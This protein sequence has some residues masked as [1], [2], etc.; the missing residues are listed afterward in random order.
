MQRVVITIDTADDVW[1][2][3]AMADLRNVAEN[4]Y[5][6]LREVGF[7]DV[8]A[9]DA[10]VC[11]FL[12]LGKTC[13]H[14]LDESDPDWISYPQTVEQEMRGTLEVYFPH[15]NVYVYLGLNDRLWGG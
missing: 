5:H 3:E 9:E 2:T 13:P 7:W 15:A 10:H 6:P 1:P 12:A 11:R 4:L 14:M 8:N